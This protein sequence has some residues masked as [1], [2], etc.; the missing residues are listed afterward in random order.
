[1]H[2]G[3]CG[4]VVAAVETRRFCNSFYQHAVACTYYHGASFLSAG[5]LIS[6]WPA[7]LAGVFRRGGFT[8]LD[9]K[10]AVTKVIHVRKV[11]ALLSGDTLT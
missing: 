5:I 1:L 9:E 10:S 8:V 11:S 2:N 6:A 7:V 4:A 3:F